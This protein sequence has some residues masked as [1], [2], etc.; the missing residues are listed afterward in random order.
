MPGWAC[1][2]SIVVLFVIPMWLY[3]LVSEHRKRKMR[4]AALAAGRME[5]VTINPMV[6]LSVCMGSGACVPACPERVFEVIEGQAVAVN[7]ADCIGH[8]ACA[9][10]CPVG[11]IELVFGSEK[12]GIDIPQVGPDFQT[13]VPGLYIAGEL[14]GM[15]LIA[16]A[17]E[18]GRQAAENAIGKGRGGGEVDLMIVGAGPAGIAAAAAAATAG[19]SYALIEQG[20]LGGAVRHYPRKKL[21][22]TRPMKIPG[23]RTVKLKTLRKEELVELFEDVVREV[24]LR[25]STGE[26]ADRVSREDDGSFTV[27]TSKRTVRAGRVILALGRRG[28]PRTL[29][30]GGEDLEKVAYSLLEPEQY[31]YEHVMVVGGGDSAVEAAL[32]LSEQPGNRVSLSYRGKHINRPK[33]KNLQLLEKA[34]A[35][36]K[37]EL[38]LGSQVREITK[39]RVVLSSGDDE[40]VRPN[41]WMFVMVGGVLPIGFL[42]DAGVRVERHY[43]RRVEEGG[44]A[45]EPKAAQPAAPKPS[46]SPELPSLQELPFTGHDEATVELGKLDFADGDG[47]EKTV[48][49]PDIEPWEPSAASQEVTEQRNR[50]SLGSPEPPPERA[51]AP[52]NGRARDPE[53]VR[54][55]AGEALDGCDA[56]GA[57]TTIE[58]YLAHVDLRGDVAPE[59]SLLLAELVTARALAGDP[60]AALKHAELAARSCGGQ[61][62]LHAVVAARRAEVEASLGRE[63]ES[64][65]LVDGVDWQAL[66]AGGAEGW[67]VADARIR[68]ARASCRIGRDDVARELIAGIGR[69]TDPELA[70][71][72][73]AVDAVSRARHRPVEAAAR[74]AEALGC[75]TSGLPAAVLRLDA[76]LALWIADDVARQPGTPPDPRARV[77]V[78]EALKLVQSTSSRGLRVELMVLLAHLGADASAV[79]SIRRTIVSHSAGLPASLSRSFTSR[80]EVAAVLSGAVARESTKVGGTG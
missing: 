40:V 25:I 49:L 54:A 9:V 14:G 39:D 45:P 74:A 21:V 52:A 79:A 26:R 72:A 24:G 41:D 53:A 19:R 37:V 17:V 48:E 44:E 63:D 50:A 20:E 31:K 10:V 69:V 28:T 22:F 12:R 66:E 55:A 70:A 64:R 35:S 7:M 36:G 68:A 51:A 75:S 4:A 77:A 27:V 57:A 11:A 2:A 38:L 71:L 1:L 33:A 5:P 6:D 42:Q 3:T 67:W 16:S 18:Q 78:K 65:A 23:Y 32:A 13:N 29:G 80:P 15:G 30:V 46:P 34:A 47:D 43:G 73:L 59:V 56:L 58:G 60:S 8:G 76:A 61:P 62:V